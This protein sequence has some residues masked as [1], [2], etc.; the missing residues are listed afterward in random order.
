M[1]APCAAGAGDL[2][3]E[4]SPDL[5]PVS[6][7]ASIVRSITKRRPNDEGY[8]RGMSPITKDAPP[9]A[10]SP[11]AWLTVTAAFIA[12]FV[13]FGVIYSFGVFIEPIAKELQT[14]RVATSAL[15]SI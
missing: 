3:P 11:R 5:W 13:V 12:G 4:I 14:G 1:N 2:R 9:A 10:D 6:S 15:F 7:L 8:A